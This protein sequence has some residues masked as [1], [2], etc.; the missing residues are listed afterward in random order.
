MNFDHT[1][2]DARSGIAILQRVALAENPLE[3]M[4]GLIGMSDAGASLWLPQ[5]SIIHTF[6]M[7][8]SLDL[9]FVNSGGMV[10]GVRLNVRPGRLVMANRGTVAILET[11]SYAQSVLSKVQI[12]DFVRIVP[13]GTAVA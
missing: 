3:L 1:V 12:G 2:I 4:V 11:K 7:R 13:N 6:G 5:T 8:F 9:L 10:L